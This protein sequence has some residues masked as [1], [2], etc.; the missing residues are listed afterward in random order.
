MLILPTEVV[1]IILEFSG[2]IKRRNGKYMNQIE[3]DS[4]NIVNENIMNKMK[5]IPIVK[6][7]YF[8]TNIYIIQSGVRVND[9]YNRH[10]LYYE[11]T[12]RNWKSKY[13]EITREFY[14]FYRERYRITF[15]KHEIEHIFLYKIANLFGFV[16]DPLYNEPYCLEYKYEYL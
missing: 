11:M 13:F 10:L 8:N 2:K 7:H 4:Y 6:N 14:Y 3:M 15:K 5:S 16:K 9:Q 12:D 1:N